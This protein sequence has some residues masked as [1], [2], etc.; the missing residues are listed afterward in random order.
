[1]THPPADGAPVVVTGY[2]EVVALLQQPGLCTPPAQAEAEAGVAG[3]HDDGRSEAALRHAALRRALAGRVVA[4]LVPSIRASAQQLID[5]FAADGQAELVRQYALPLAARVLAQALAVPVEALAQ[6]DAANRNGEPF[7][8]AALIVTAARRLLAHP[9]LP[10]DA[11]ER[12]VLLTSLVEETLRLLSPVAAVSRTLC[13]ATAVGDER[14]AAGTPLVLVYAAAN[15][16]PRVYPAPDRYDRTRPNVHTHLAFGYG[17][18]RCP[19][20]ALARRLTMLALATLLERL[21]DLAGSPANGD[22]WTDPWL[23]CAV[24]FTRTAAWSRS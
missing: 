3:V 16:D 14:R 5:G 1:M 8:T 12:G 18:H 11:G 15:R 24:T 4:G 7:N 9:H 2:R 17:P 19:G 13:R 6:D 10:T 20:A 23:P 22:V 21:P